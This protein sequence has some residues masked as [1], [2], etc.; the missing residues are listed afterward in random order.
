MENSKLD[1]LIKETDFHH[2]IQPVMDLSENKTFG[3]EALI[4]SPEFQSPELLF[5]YVEKQNQLFDLDMLSILKAFK[6]YRREFRKSDGSYLFIKVFPSTL[7]DQAFYYSLQW[8]IALSK[9]DPKSIVFVINEPRESIDLSSI[10]EIVADLK[11]QGFL[12][13]LDNII[14]GTLT[15]KV[16]ADIA[17]NLVKLDQHFAKSLNITAEKQSSVEMMLHLLGED[18]TLVLG[19]VENEEDLNKAIELGVPLG[20]GFFLG[21]PQ[22]IS[23]YI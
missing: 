1:L 6:T 3:Y 14:S 13:A 7:V 10:K 20:Q 4:R 12:I 19:G 21:K 22:Q 23:D 15:L 5:R 16:I 18:I 17:P 2:V 8:I 11:N 9:I